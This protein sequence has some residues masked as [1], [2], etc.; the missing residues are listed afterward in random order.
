MDADLPRAERGRAVC[1]VHPPALHIERARVRVVEAWG[2][3]NVTRVQRGEDRGG[4]HAARLCPGPRGVAARR[5]A[6]LVEIHGHGGQIGTGATVRRQLL[7]QGQAYAYRRR[8]VW[9]RDL[10]VTCVG[11]VGVAR[12]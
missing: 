2:R 4:T 3:D 12:S 1:R 6:I 11:V 8:R 7:A 10:V 5:G 9:K